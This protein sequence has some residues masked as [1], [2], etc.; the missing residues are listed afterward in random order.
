MSQRANLPTFGLKN[1][2]DLFCN[3]KHHPSP[4]R[5]WK[6]GSRN[7]YVAGQTSTAATVDNIASPRPGGDRAGEPGDGLMSRGRREE[8]GLRPA[9]RTAAAHVTNGPTCRLQAR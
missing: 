8:P 7:V 3:S 4:Q 9:L 2:I 5:S 1:D 6:P